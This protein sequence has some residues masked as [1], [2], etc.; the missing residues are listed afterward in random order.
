MPA[1]RQEG[2][3]FFNTCQIFNVLDYGAMR[4]KGDEEG[5]IEGRSDM[6]A[7]TWGRVEG[8][9]EYLDNGLAGEGVGDVAAQAGSG[10][11]GGTK[12]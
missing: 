7:G 6:G 10:Q 5:G 3:R 4:M 1:W 12:A 8:E 11:H 2:V 9:V